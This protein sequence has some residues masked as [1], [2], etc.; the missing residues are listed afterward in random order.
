MENLEEKVVPGDSTGWNRV[1]L[2]GPWWWRGSGQKGGGV[3]TSGGW[4]GGWEHVDPSVQGQLVGLAKPHL[5]TAGIGELWSLR[6]LPRKAAV[7]SEHRWGLAG[8]ESSN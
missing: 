8:G 6:D 4:Y 7:A 3:G 1:H 2:P 5:Q